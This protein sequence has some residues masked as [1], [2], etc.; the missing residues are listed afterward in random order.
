MA[1][2]KAGKMA[3][4]FGAVKRIHFIGIG[5]A[6]MSGIA[7]VLLSLHYKVTGSDLKETDVTERLT[8]MGAAINF[9]HK[10]ANVIGADVVV[11]SAADC[12]W[13]TRK[14]WRRNQKSIPVIARTEMLAGVDASPNTVSLFLARAR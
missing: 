12:R 9:G 1:K 3:Q 8:Q 10:A 14:L 13:T 4:P 2:L 11:Y 5:G 7:A 6:G